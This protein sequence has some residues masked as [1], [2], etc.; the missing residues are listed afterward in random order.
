MADRAL[1]WQRAGAIAW[2]DLKSA[3]GKFAFVVLSV[4]VGAHK[5]AHTA[6][7][8]LMTSEKEDVLTYLQ[9][10]LT[11]GQELLVYPYL[12]LYN[13][14]NKTVYRPEIKGLNPN[15][16]NIIVLKNISKEQ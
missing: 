9:S 13:Y 4:A 6:R 11:P 10:H 8:T 7:G 15:P 3:P 16:R 12:P 14:V 5:T 1:S 2:R